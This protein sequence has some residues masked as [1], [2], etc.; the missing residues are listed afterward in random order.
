[1]V[2]EREERGRERETKEVEGE[3]KGLINNIY[4]VINNI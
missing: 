4:S 3:K 1:M 2:V